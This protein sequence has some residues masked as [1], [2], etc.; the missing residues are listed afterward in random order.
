MEKWFSVEEAIIGGAKW[1]SDGYLNRTP[2]NQNT[3]FKMRYNFPENMNHEYATD[4]AWAKSQS[5]FIR[6]QVE[7][8]NKANNTDIDLV[9]IYPTFK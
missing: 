2:V 3:L 7:A 6:E 4:V 5:G 8:Y 1:I 9:Y